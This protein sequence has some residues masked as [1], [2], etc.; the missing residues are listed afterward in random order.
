MRIFTTISVALLACASALAYE[1]KTIAGHTFEIAPVYNFPEILPEVKERTVSADHGYSFGMMVLAPDDICLGWIGYDA[2]SAAQLVRL[3]LEGDII[4]QSVLPVVFSGQD[5]FTPERRQIFVGNDTEGNPFLST[6]SNAGEQFRIYSCGLSGESVETAESYA[7]AGVDDYFTREVSVY[8]N[9]SSGSFTAAAPFWDGN[10]SIYGQAG[11]QGIGIWQYNA[12]EAESS[13]LSKLNTSFFYPTVQA[14]GGN[15]LLVDNRGLGQSSPQTYSEPSVFQILSSGSLSQKSYIEGD[16]VPGVGCGAHIFSFG[17]QWFIIYLAERLGERYYQISNLPG[18]PYSI[19]DAEPVWAL[20]EEIPQYNSDFG[21][22]KIDDGIL[23]T[24]FITTIPESD[25]T[26]S[27]YILTSMRGLAKYTLSDRSNVQ[28]SAIA[29]D[30][31]SEE[32]RIYNLSGIL[33][34]APLAPGVYI[35]V[36]GSQRR[37]ILVK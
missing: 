10:Y 13:R 4:Q 9:I 22:Y 3:R 2:T 7:P 28:T 35:E 34:Q 12:A 14:L 33:V 37:R 20:K 1:P 5:A 6:P 31:P 36:C 30:L 15:W 19:Y 32:V 18:Y 29:I 26:L 11:K 27:L 21:T 25:N 24:S 23:D 16:N 8:G 17:D